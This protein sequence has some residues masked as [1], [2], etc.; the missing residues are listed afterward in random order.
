M[1]TTEAEFFRAKRTWSK[2]KDEVLANYLSP[3]L[4]KVARLGKKIVFVDAFAG[5]GIFKD[6]SRGSPLIIC[7]QAEKSVPNK[8][9][10]V[11]VNGEKESHQTLQ[12]VLKNYI[13][14]KKVRCICGT[15]E[16]LL[17]ALKSLLT[18]Q[19]LFLYLDPFG[20][21]GCDFNLIKPYLEREKRRYSTEIIINMSMPTLHRLATYRAVLEKRET[22]QTKTLNKKLTGVLG[23]D[24]WREIMWNEK[25]TPEDKETQ[26]IQKYMEL[27][28]QYLPFI[29]SCPVREKTGKRVKYYMI[30]CSRHNHAMFLMNDIM[31][32]AYFERMYEENYKGTLFEHLDW[33]STRDVGNIEDIILEEVSQTP[34]LTRKEVWLSI[35]QKYF[36][37]WLESEYRTAVQKLVNKGE[38]YSPTKR[39]TSR[40]NYKC[41]LYPKRKNNPQSLTVGV[42]RAVKRKA[43][44]RKYKLLTGK[45]VELVEKVGDGSIIKRFD[46]T[47]FPKKTNDVVCPHFLELK[48][49]YGCPYDCSWCYLNGTL[50]FQPNGK[51]PVIKP[52]SKVEMH[53]KFFLD[54]CNVPEVLNTGEIADSLMSENTEEPF[55]KFIIPIF[56]SQMKHRVLF[57]TKSPNIRNFLDFGSCN[58][59]IMSFS[60]NA[61]PVAE[62]WEKAPKVIKRIEAGQKLYKE[63][64]EVRIRIDPMVP[65]RNWEKHYL[66]LIDMIFEKFIPERITLGSLRGLQSTINRSHDRSWVKYLSENSSWGK[67]VE[68]TT[69]Y[70]MYSRLIDYMKEKY[71]Y[72]DV[73]LCKETL[74]MWRKLQM[75]Y[76]QIKCN[77]IW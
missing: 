25:L 9:F 23:G 68:T 8:Y 53:T 29:G 66:N 27:L 10:A 5:R 44:W 30:F 43:K 51:S 71:S 57:L 18:N 49:A 26:V 38:I 46:K 24:W 21:K 36:M 13:N 72:K 2:V 22:R 31:H 32:K 52:Y 60:V 73:A 39:K 58:Q 48:W 7:E 3:Y 4:A 69:R 40:L 1:K 19:T 28:K 62:K 42:E 65:I 50:R 41:T 45:E 74:K 76:K 47:P 20:L 14:Q 6:G 11:F 67:K 12:K 35:I 70:Q 64:F 34:G 61:F 54:E 17:E 16:D 59:V 15:A 56:E 63:G 75:D 37:R 33:R 77:C 55:S